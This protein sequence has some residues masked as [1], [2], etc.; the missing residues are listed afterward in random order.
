MA[1]AALGLPDARGAFAFLP[2]LE[3][4]R[5]N[6]G[7]WRQPRNSPA[8]TEVEWVSGSAASLPCGSF[9]THGMPA[10]DVTV[11]THGKLP[12]VL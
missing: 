3:H 8:Q 10:P 4:A 2:A 5:E 6:L 12:C 7:K 9:L 1:A 11:D